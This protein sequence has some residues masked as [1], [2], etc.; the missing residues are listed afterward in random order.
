MASG[1]LQ[2]AVELGKDMSPALVTLRPSFASRLPADG[3]SISLS[4]WTAAESSSILLLTSLM[5]S[6]AAHHPLRRLLDAG[7]TCQAPHA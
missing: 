3:A 4:F 7:G 5:T 1:G 6:P 2:V